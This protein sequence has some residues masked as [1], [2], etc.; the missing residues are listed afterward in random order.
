[1]GNCLRA[2]GKS[3]ARYLVRNGLA[4][5]WPQYSRGEYAKE[6]ERAKAARLGL[7]N[8]TFTTPWD[9]RAEQR[10]KDNITGSSASTKGCVIKGNISRKGARIYH[11]PGQKDFATTRIDERKGERWFCSEREAQAA[12]WIPASR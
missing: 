7:W 3:V 4:L 12:G 9:W 5:D 10:V 6:Q 11:L 1:V 8:G 2:D